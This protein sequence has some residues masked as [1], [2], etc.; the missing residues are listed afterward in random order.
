[1]RVRTNGKYVK[2]AEV[3][4]TLSG[5]LVDRELAEYSTI[6]VIQ[7]EE[8]SY[9]RLIGGKDLGNKMDMAENGDFVAIKFL[10]WKKLSS[11]NSYMLSSVDIEKPTIDIN[12]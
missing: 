10:G 8:N 2:L 5:W 1:M 3:T 11:G 9:V 6:Y 4:G 7:T 12:P